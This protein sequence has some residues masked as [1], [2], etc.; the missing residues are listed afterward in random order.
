MGSS[1][2]HGPAPAAT[3]RSSAGKKAL[4]A[5]DHET[6]TRFDAVQEITIKV[7]AERQKPVADTGKDADQKRHTKTN[8]F[9]IKHLPYQPLAAPH[10]RDLCVRFSGE[11]AAGGKTSRTHA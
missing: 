2:D 1:Y 4:Q 3:R 9:L 6:K 7:K 10:Q 8:P 5:N 11:E